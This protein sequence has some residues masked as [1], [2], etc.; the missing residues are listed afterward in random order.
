MILKPDKSGVFGSRT[1]AEVVLFLL[2]VGVVLLLNWGLVTKLASQPRSIRTS[3]ISRQSTDQ[4]S[5]LAEMKAK[6]T[7]ASVMYYSKQKPTDETVEAMRLASCSDN[8][9]VAHAAQMCL[10][11]WRK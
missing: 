6:P 2:V 9:Q 7:L 1:V 11:K 4:D 8:P 3:D 10:S 5:R